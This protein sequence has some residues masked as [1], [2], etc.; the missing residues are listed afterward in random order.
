M[1][2][3]TNQFKFFSKGRYCWDCTCDPVCQIWS[4]YL[5]L[6]WSY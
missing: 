5:Q 4:S 2:L 6:F 1:S 3:T